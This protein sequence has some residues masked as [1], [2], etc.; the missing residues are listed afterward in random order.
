MRLPESTD[1]PVGNVLLYTR[2]FV[3]SPSRTEVIPGWHGVTT[4]SGF[5]LSAHPLLEITQVVA[6]D[7]ELTLIGFVLDPDHPEDDNTRILSRI[8]TD[9]VT[10]MDVVRGSCRMG[11]RWILIVDSSEESFLFT[12]PCA[13]RQVC[14]MRDDGAVWCASQPGILAESFDLQMSDAAR[15]FIGSLYFKS[16]L[17]YWWPGGRTPFAEVQQLLPNHLLDLR[18][19]AVRRFW[20]WAPLAEVGFDQAVARGTEILTSTIASAGRRSALALP[21]TGGLD[22]RVLLAASRDL[23]R[24]IFFYTLDKRRSG[25]SRMD[26]TVA[27]NMLR[28]LGL[29]HNV[30]DCNVGVDPDFE[31][32]YQRNVVTAHPEW[33]VIVDALRRQYPPRHLVLNGNC[34]EIARCYYRHTPRGAVSKGREVDAGYLAYLENMEGNNLALE[35]FHAWLQGAPTPEERGRIE[36][37]D[38][39]Y[40]EQRMGR[41]QAMSQLEWDLAQ[42]TLSPYNNRELLTLLLGVDPAR[43]DRPD[44][45][46]A[47]IRKLWPELLAEPINPVPISRRL[48]EA[49]KRGVFAALG[50]STLF[51]HA[52]DGYRKMRSWSRR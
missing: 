35:E 51:R 37:L 43:R 41:W 39:F 27:G 9:A 2:Q 32:I 13:L 47:M 19:G 44:L 46:M 15:A 20:P 16:Y 45:F 25:D 36:L 33:A 23:Q 34:A 30:I 50:N 11:G 42:E 17:E 40:W 8:A 29:S 18:S 14:Y 10:N 5:H 6:R 3:L 52:L 21:V 24:D 12:D 4:R 22:S 48:T 49:A 1:R 7:L 26:I 28:R 38:L 31:A